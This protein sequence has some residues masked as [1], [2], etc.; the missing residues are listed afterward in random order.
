M[1]RLAL[2]FGLLLCA[3]PVLAQ[4]AAQGAEPEFRTLKGH[5]GPV[6]AIAVAPSG[7]VATGSFDNSVGVWSA[8]APRNKSITASR[9]SNTS[10]SPPDAR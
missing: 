9:P 4:E 5:G 3:A 2:A 7:Q 6:M 10:G 1:R 8:I